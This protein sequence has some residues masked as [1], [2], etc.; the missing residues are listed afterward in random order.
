M[1]SHKKFL[2]LGSG[3]QL[4]RSF[5]AELTVRGYRFSAP[6]ETD[7]DITRPEVM[8]CLLDT[9]KPDVVINCAAYNN[10]E[11]AQTDMTIARAINAE[12]VENI[13]RLCHETG[14]FLI[15][16][17]TDYV[18]DGN[19]NDLYD[20]TDVPCP[21][22]HYGR[23]KL[24]GEQAVLSVA[25][26][27]LVLRVSWV[28]GPGKQNFL[29]KLS[30]WAKQRRILKISADETSVPTW[31][32]DIVEVTLAA[33]DQGLSGL[34]HLTSGGYASRYEWSKYFLEEG[35]FRN[36]VIPVAVSEFPSTVRRPLFS[37]LSNRKISQVLGISIPHWHEGVK[38]YLRQVTSDMS[39]E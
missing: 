33:L 2:I 7:S 13:A 35:K 34:Y 25:P 9:E 38:N 20:E 27:S 26:D 23:S 11:Q 16:Y 10:V 29:Y 32:G 3:G 12:A 5:V 28:Y 4:G 18:F 24:E 17:G 19:K 39:L 31:V 8:R 1:A 37:C 15:H 22:N 14:I 36:L 30:G 6:A 21:L